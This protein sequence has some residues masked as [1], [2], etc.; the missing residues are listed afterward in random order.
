[1]ADVQCPLR[2]AALI[3]PHQVAIECGDVR[4]L[5]SELDTRVSDAVA[6]LRLAGLREGDRVGLYLPPDERMI[7]LLMAVLRL[8]AI[9]CPLNLRWP[10]D[11][12]RG[13]LSRLR[14]AAVIAQA[15]ADPTSP[16]QVLPPET[17]LAGGSAPVPWD[18]KMALDRPATAIFTSG[19]AGRPKMALHTFGN[20]YYS[21]RGANTNL[22]VRSGD[23]WLLSLPLY[24]VGGLGI[25]F[26]CLL[27][28]AAMAFSA[29][30]EDLHDAVVRTKATHVSLV[31]TQLRRLLDRA[32]WDPAWR[33]VKVALVGGGPVAPTLLAEAHARGLP[34]FFSYGLTEMASQVTCVRPDTPPARQSTSGSVLRHRQ[35]RIADDGEILVRGETLFS[36]YLQDDGAVA[37]ACD[38]EGWFATGDLGALSEDGYLTVQGRRDNLFISGGENIQPEEIEQALQV[39]PGIEQAVIVPVPDAE[40]GERPAAVVQGDVSAAPAWEKRLREILPGYMIPVCWLPW[41]DGEGR[42]GKADRAAVRAYARAARGEAAR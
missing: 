24:H 42:M 36:G 19:S 41:P 23:R 9:A 17:L 21:A 32:A 34:V 22:R 25:V 15:V 28:G 2:A 12:V 27:G 1:M 8:G 40:F 37:S 7:L 39:L 14:A 11:A 26:R 33:N 16:W 18:G 20:H 5:Y 31:G 38:A 29:A 4:I 30:G 3:S 6:Y 13:A 10:R 35:L